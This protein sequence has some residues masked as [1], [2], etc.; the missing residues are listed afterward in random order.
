LDKHT[1]ESLGN[2]PTYFVPLGVS[3]WLKKEKIENVVELDWWQASS[4]KGL[5]FHSVPVQHFSGRSPFD[6][7]KTLWSGWV[8]E[9]KQGKVFF[10][11]DTGYS[12]VF[13]EIGERFGPMRISIIPIGA[14]MPRWFMKPFHVDPPEAVRIHQD[15]NSWQ[16]IASHWG[17]FKLSDEPI[18][19][20]PR[21]LE[22][23]LREAGVDEKRFII[24]R[25]G[26]TR[27]FR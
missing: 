24:M 21:Y 13:K 11:G 22:K 18:G 12:P 10:A 14:Y 8:I 17:T 16:S 26:E 25:F 9:G 15:T 3:R 5:R 2:K 6:R 23:A 27:S 1:V 20:P 7:N 4:S 19:E